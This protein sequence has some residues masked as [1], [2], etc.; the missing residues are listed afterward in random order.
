M[1]RVPE[2]GRVLQYNPKK[3]MSGR[4][5]LAVSRCLHRHG[6]RWK[7]PTMDFGWR[8]RD[9][10]ELFQRRHNQNPDGV[11][12]EPVHKY[13]APLFD[14]YEHWLYTHAPVVPKPPSDEAQKR[15]RLMQA[16]WTLYAQRPWGYHAVRPFILYPVG[17]HIAYAFDC[18]WMVTQVFYM[19]G[20][21][22]PNG[23]NYRGGIGNTSTLAAHGTRVSKPTAGDLAFYSNPDHVAMISNEAGTMDI[24][25]G[26]SGG[27]R[28][29]GVN[30]RP[31]VEFRSYV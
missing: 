18:S 19:A 13:L 22:D 6:Y 26:S 12:D 27:P 17:K 1:T 20:L 28:L 5:V 23:L 15:G 4:D 29:L 8:M 24:G 30:Y 11:Y 9:N 7:E 25:F 14:G 3:V 21:P 31:V 10:V 16:L 2:F